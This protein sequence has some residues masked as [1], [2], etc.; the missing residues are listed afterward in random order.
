M[1]WWL[2]FRFDRVVVMMFCLLGCNVQIVKD[3][4]FLL[5][6]SFGKGMLVIVCWIFFVVRDVVIVNFG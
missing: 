1:S 2:F 3:Y 6:L 5:W 4:E